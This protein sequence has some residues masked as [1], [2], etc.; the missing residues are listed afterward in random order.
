[1]K[2]PSASE[3]LQVWEQGVAKKPIQQALYLLSAACPELSMEDHLAKLTMGQRDRLLLILREWLFGSQINCVAQC[4]QCQTE[5]E[6]DFNIHDIWAA[7]V[8][9]EH[10][11]QTLTLDSYKVSFRLPNSLDIIAAAEAKVDAQQHLLE[12]CLL[13][14]YFGQAECAVSQL[15]ATVK[16]AIVEQMAKVDA[17][18]DIEIQ[19]TCPECSKQWAASFDIVTFLW[20]EL[21]N[22]AGRTLREV[23]QLASAYSWREADIL[24]MSATRRQLYLEMLGQ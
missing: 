1:M 13:H 2:V 12:S 10:C 5:L 8:D 9:S 19:L 18:A 22:W 15:P 17:Q 7:W 3:L 23:H 4:P 14:T 20:R 11:V 24:A 16:T 21:H 6:V